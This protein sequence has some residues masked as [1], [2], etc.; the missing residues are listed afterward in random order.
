MYLIGAVTHG[1]RAALSPSAK[2]PTRKARSPHS[3]RSWPR[4]TR[5]GGRSPSTRCTPI[6]RGYENG[7]DPT[8][9]IRDPSAWGQTH[10]RIPLSR[11]S[12]SSSWQSAEI[13][14]SNRLS[15]QARQGFRT[16]RW[17]GDNATAAA[18]LEC[19][20]WRRL[21]K[22]SLGRPSRAC[23]PAPTLGFFFQ[24]RPASSDRACQP[25]EPGQI[26]TNW[27][28]FS[29]P[30]M[31]LSRMAVHKALYRL[32]P[33]QRTIATHVVRAVAARSSVMTATWCY[34]EQR[35]LASVATNGPDLAV[36]GGSGGAWVRWRGQLGG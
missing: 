24:V 22:R 32:P 36:P 30:R 35:T 17:Q 31:T 1:E 5:P 16:S 25:R 10:D 33:Q 3:C 6:L 11:L 7:T 15:R 34:G 20:L 19:Q 9:F 4:W 13:S 12:P 23:E 14:P 18:Y 28:G 27:A 26:P 2:S 8:I 29:R 21:P